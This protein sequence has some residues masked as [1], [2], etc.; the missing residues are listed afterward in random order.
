MYKIRFKPI[1]PELDSNS[2]IQIINESSMPV[3]I[4]KI[5][6]AISMQIQNAISIL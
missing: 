6:N 5:Q 2:F 1:M 3:I 4:Y